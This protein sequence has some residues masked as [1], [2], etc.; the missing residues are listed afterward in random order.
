MPPVIFESRDI[1]GDGRFVQEVRISEFTRTASLPGGL[2]YSLCLMDE[3]THDVILLYDVHRG[4]SDHRHLRG[5][6]TR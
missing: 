5:E 4:K 6:E 1:V 2:R 3:K